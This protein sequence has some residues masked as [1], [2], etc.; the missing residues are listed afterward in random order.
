MIGPIDHPIAFI[1]IVAVGLVALWLLPG[2]DN[3]KNS[4]SDNSDDNRKS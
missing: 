4:G 3:R 1:L 2:D